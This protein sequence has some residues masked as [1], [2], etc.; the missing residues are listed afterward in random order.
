MQERN[1][2]FRFQEQTIEQAIVQKLARSLSGLHSVELL[3]ERGLFQE[4]GMMQRVVDEIDEDIRF[5]SLAVINNDVTSLHREFLQYFYAE[6]F[7]DEN[8][9][10]GSHQSRGMIKREKIR[11]YVHSTLFSDADREKA[12]KADKILTKTYSGYV[13]GA[14]PHIMDMY[15]REGFDVSGALK[16]YRY[17]SHKLD[18]RNVYYRAIIAMAFAAKAFGNE[19][20]FASLHE[21]TK[22]VDL[23]M[24]S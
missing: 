24:H 19:K 23:E 12:K 1:G 6:E 11:A 18:A 22:V 4:Q 15:F 14:S 8:D 20:L 9:V 16:H 7:A 21:L 10:F 2:R 5:L 13:H 17:S 3:L